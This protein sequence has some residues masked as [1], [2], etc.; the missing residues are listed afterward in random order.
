MWIKGSGGGGWREEAGREDGSGQWEWRGRDRAEGERREEGS[1]PLHRCGTTL[2]MEN[3]RKGLCWG[4]MLSSV[5]HRAFEALGGRE[6]QLWVL[7]EGGR[8]PVETCSEGSRELWE[9]L[10]QSRKRVGCRY[11]KL[12]AG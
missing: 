7:G 3:P 8:Q 10:E 4:K 6:M 5:E 1:Q 12:Q 9:E 2:E 11:L